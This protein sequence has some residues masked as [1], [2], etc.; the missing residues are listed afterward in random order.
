MRPPWTIMRRMRITRL[1]AVGMMLAMVRCPTDRPPF[2]SQ[3]TKKCKHPPQP[4]RC[5]QACM[6]QLSVIPKTNPKA[7]GQPVEENPQSKTA[8]S[9]R[10]GSEQ[11]SDMQSDQPHRRAPLHM[12]DLGNAG[13][14]LAP[15]FHS[16]RNG[17]ILGHWTRGLWRERRGV[18]LFWRIPCRRERM[19]WSSHENSRNGAR[20]GTLF[21][22]PA[23]SDTTVAPASK[24]GY[25]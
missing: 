14:S 17:N 9:E 15:R 25:E 24:P 5:F 21:G 20:N 10:P 11:A 22:D 6:G 12:V 8:P 3:R 16:H 7:T 13:L 2:S 18:M 4:Q 1:I 19:R 23:G